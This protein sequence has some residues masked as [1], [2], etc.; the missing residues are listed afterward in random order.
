MF[1]SKSGSLIQA[2]GSEVVGWPRGNSETQQPGNCRRDRINR[3][4]QYALRAAVRGAYS[5]GG[6]LVLWARAL[7]SNVGV[8]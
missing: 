7:G 6:S 4:W 2:W 5:E 1:L 8:V 3:P